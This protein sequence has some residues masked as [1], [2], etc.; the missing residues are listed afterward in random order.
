MRVAKKMNH[1][2][3]CIESRI[4]FIVGQSHSEKY[5][6]YAVI[7]FVTENDPGSVQSVIE[8]AVESRNLDLVKTI[9]KISKNNQ[10]RINFDIV[11]IKL[12]RDI[13]YEYGKPNDI[14]HELFHYL[15]DK[16]NNNNNKISSKSLRKIKEQER[17]CFGFFITHPKR[18]KSVTDMMKTLKSQGKTIL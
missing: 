16:N 14:H 12:F 6:N 15:L 17:R 2:E 10:I 7:K 9:F 8:A 1:N 13:F 5:I 4:L 3:Y 18:K 11:F